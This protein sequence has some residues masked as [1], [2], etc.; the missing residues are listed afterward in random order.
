MGALS[1]KCVQ[2]L[3]FEL[4]KMLGKYGLVLFI[5]KFGKAFLQSFSSKFWS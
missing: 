3:N 5:V 1:K 2:L 4:L